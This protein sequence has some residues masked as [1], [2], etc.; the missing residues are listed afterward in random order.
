MRVLRCYSSEPSRPAGGSARQLPSSVPATGAGYSASPLRSVRK[1]CSFLAALT[2]A[3]LVPFTTTQADVVI[4]DARPATLHVG[5][6]S[7]T[8]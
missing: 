4:G 2:I 8:I 7:T 1:Q 6:N 3:T 5:P